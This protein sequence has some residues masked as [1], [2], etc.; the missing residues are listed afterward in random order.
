[1][2]PYVC[3]NIKVY[4]E[5][6]ALDLESYVSFLDIVEKGVRKVQGDVCRKM[7]K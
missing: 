1:M 6:Y 2:L 3:L 7:C 5:L 4:K